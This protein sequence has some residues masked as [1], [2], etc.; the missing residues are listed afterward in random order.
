MEV[1]LYTGVI[2]P[3]P[4]VFKSDTEHSTAYIINSWKQPCGGDPVH[5]SSKAPARLQYPYLRTRRFRWYTKYLLTPYQFVSSTSFRTYQVGTDGHRKLG[6]MEISTHRGRTHNSS[7]SLPAVAAAPEAD[8]HRQGHAAST[9]F[10]NALSW[11]DSRLAD[12]YHI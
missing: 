4:G 6:R 7:L 9:R 11:A 2:D 12:D 3:T 10:V 8:R 1:V 5:P